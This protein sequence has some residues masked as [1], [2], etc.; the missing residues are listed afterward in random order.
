MVDQKPKTSSKH[1]IN[2]EYI[3]IIGQTRSKDFGEK[4]IIFGNTK[5]F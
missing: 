4:I 2:D 1:Q 3:Y 5:V